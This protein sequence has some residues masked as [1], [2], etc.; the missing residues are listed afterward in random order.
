MNQLLMFAH[1]ESTLSI[2]LGNR[3][4]SYVT[5]CEEHTNSFFAIW[6]MSVTEYCRRERDSRHTPCKDEQNGNNFGLR[7]TKDVKLNHEVYAN[8]CV[9]NC[10]YMSHR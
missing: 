3:C 1:A 9:P 5:K 2:E 6:Q 4:G 10:S 7:D 8:T